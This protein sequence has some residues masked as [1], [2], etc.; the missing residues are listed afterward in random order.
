[1]DKYGGIQEE[2]IEPTEREP[3]SSPAFA[4]PPPRPWSEFATPLTFTARKRGNDYVNERIEEGPLTP[5]VKRVKLKCDKYVE[6]K[7]QSSELYRQ[8]LTNILAYKATTDRRANQ[9]GTIIQKYGEIY[10]NVARRQIE[11]SDFEASRVQ[12]LLENRRAKKE[13]AD[14]EKERKRAAKALNTASNSVK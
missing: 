6:T 8:R 13:A 11:W 2:P 12:N 5:T 3:S 1:M 7:L 9:P 14:A 4:T 10:G